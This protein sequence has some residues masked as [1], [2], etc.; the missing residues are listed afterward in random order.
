MASTFPSKSYGHHVVPL[1]RMLQE[2]EVSAKRLMER[3]RLWKKKF[4]LGYESKNTIDI[5]IEGGKQMINSQQNSS[6][7]S[8]TS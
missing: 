2:V 4:R 7:R 6:F 3:E 5:N 8:E 1:P